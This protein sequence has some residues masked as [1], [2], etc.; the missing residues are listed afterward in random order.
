MANTGDEV[1]YLHYFDFVNFNKLRA[2]FLLNAWL[3]F[4]W[5]FV[6]LYLC[7]IPLNVCLFPAELLSICSIVQLVTC[8]VEVKVSVCVC[9]VV[10]KMSVPPVQ[11]I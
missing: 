11:Y 6:P 5:K 2:K 1:I 4:V 9:Y 3:V 7:P 8:A 10:A